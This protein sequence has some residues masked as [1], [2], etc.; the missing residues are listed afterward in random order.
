[1]EVW[2]ENSSEDHQILLHIS[3]SATEMLYRDIM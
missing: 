3:D 2:P 1:M